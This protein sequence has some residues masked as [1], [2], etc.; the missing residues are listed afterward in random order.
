[1]RF[2]QWLQE[3]TQEEQIWQQVA[4]WQPT[5]KKY[6]DRLAKH[7]AEADDI[8][9]NA[10]MSAFRALKNGNI[11]RNVDF[12]LFSI[13]RNETRNYMR[14]LSKRSL[15]LT[16]ELPG[17]IQPD[18][19]SDQEERDKLRHQVGDALGDLKPDDHD[20]LKNLYYDNEP[21][22]KSAERLQVPLGTI[23]RRLHT[24]RGRLKDA[25]EKR[26]FGQG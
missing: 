4:E 8:A 25:L 26:G 14:G 21:I 9:Q 23:K 13:V 12:W 7:R 11:P 24:A 3:N 22:K 16:M 1:M 17:A 19:R 2:S 15:P 5:I 18:E 6:A 10:S 20:A